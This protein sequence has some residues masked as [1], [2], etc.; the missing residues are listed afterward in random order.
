MENHRRWRQGFNKPMR[1]GVN[2]RCAFG[3]HATHK[4]DMHEADQGQSDAPRLDPA[5][6]PIRFASTASCRQIT[7]SLVLE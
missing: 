6:A 1:L 5:N 2:K 3:V 7:L 4:C